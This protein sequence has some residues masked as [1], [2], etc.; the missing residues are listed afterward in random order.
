MSS[1]ILRAEHFSTN[2]IAEKSVHYCTSQSKFAVWVAP[3]RTSVR[4]QFFWLWASDTAQ[5]WFR[6]KL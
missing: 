4:R 5:S 1:F 6:A 3:E 2:K